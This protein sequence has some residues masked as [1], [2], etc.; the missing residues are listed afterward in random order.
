MQGVQG[1]LRWV[2]GGAV[3]LL[4]GVIGWRLAAGSYK[5]DIQKICNA[6]KNAGLDA[7]AD[8]QKTEKWAK[9]HLDTPEA[10]TWFSELLKKGL[11][12]R[13]NGLEAESK[14]YAVNECPLVGAYRALEATAEYRKD[15]F[16]L[17]ALPNLDALDDDARLKKMVDWIQ[18]SSKTARI[19]PLADKLTQTDANQRSNLV[20]ATANDATVYACE[21]ANVLA[22]PPTVPKSDKPIVAF[23]QPQ[24]NGEL[25]VEQLTSPVLPKVDDVN[26]CY[27]DA[28]AQ[29]PDLTG[30]IMLKLAIS[31]E[32][33]VMRE[34]VEAGTSPVE[35][36]LTKCI[37]DI[38]QGITFPKTGG[39]A[40]RVLWPLDLI[41]KPAPLA[42]DPHG[43]GPGGH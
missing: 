1:W 9:E 37:G 26:K 13:A 18:N 29:K 43:H 5:A 38:I 2:L 14:K 32:G 30:R 11:I 20:R 10:A 33:K 15:L 7:Q 17:C 28:L 19:K 22:R 4:V 8:L 27:A 3:L 40:I 41:P 24:I 36:A 42:E 12:D 35:R 16:G 23:G 6:E 25:T 39:I 34:T 31:P 21:L